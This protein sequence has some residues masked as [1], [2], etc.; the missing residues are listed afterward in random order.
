MVLFIIILVLASI[1]F[2]IAM[3]LNSAYLLSIYVFIILVVIIYA[4]VSP[5]TDTRISSPGEPLGRA[6]V[7]SILL[8]GGIGGA[9]VKSFFLARQH[10][11]MKRALRD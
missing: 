1:P 2:G 6:I 11:R 10:Y 7:S 5:S 3:F 9:I 8:V 4:I